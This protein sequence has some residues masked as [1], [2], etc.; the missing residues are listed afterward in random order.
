MPLNKQ[1]ILRLKF[2][3][4]NLKSLDAIKGKLAEVKTSAISTSSGFEKLRG[5]GRGV[6]ESFGFITPE[7]IAV[8]QRYAMQIEEIKSRHAKLRESAVEL[9]HKYALLKRTI[10]E[11]QKQ[12]SAY[13]DIVSDIE[14]HKR[15]LYSVR[16]ELAKI[17]PQYKTYTHLVKNTTE[18]EKRATQEK[19]RQVFTTRYWG[20]VFENW[21]GKIHG[22]QEELSKIEDRR[23][24]QTRALTYASMRLGKAQ[25][26]LVSA[27]MSL[28]GVF[29]S[30]FSA[31]FFLRTGFTSLISPITDLDTAI[32][33]LVL[34][35]IFGDENTKKLAS[36]ILGL[37]KDTD[38]TEKKT[39]KLID[40][41][42]TWQSIT[43]TA[44]VVSLS[45]AVGILGDEE[46]KQKLGEIKTKLIEIAGDEETR[47]AV[48]NLF[49]TMLNMLQE[50]LKNLP[51]IINWFNSMLG[52]LQP[53]LGTVVKLSIFAMIFMIPLAI[54][55]MLVNQ[56]IILIGVL[57][58]LLLWL[59]GADN[60][61]VKFL[62]K[63]KETG[64][65]TIAMNKLKEAI[66]GV[67]LASKLFSPYTL[68]LT[69][70]IILFAILYKKSD[71][72]REVIQKIVNKF[73]EF[74]KTIK[75][76][77]PFL[78]LLGS[79]FGV[80]GGVFKGI[81]GKGVGE[82]FIGG[83]IGEAID[84]KLQ[85]E[86]GKRTITEIGGGGNV[87]QQSSQ[88][89]NETIIMHNDID[90]IH[91]IDELTNT[92]TKSVRYRSSDAV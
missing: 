69:G 84:K 54:I 34:G 52:I 66:K 82:A 73:K 74:G 4:E 68:I 51:S 9:S 17:T 8:N 56:I 46:V 80:A 53:I 18:I 38:D 71:K 26:F 32:N 50:L 7:I 1:A 86:I 47:N 29:F 19:R 21:L 25:Q 62:A 10:R 85:N 5:V 58:K 41:W 6:A 65:L 91:D 75:E 72:F 79:I 36:S 30:L 81:I 20:S 49:L 35:F 59:T 24:R 64:L 63:T 48:K 28:L 33:S 83:N 22:R 16:T 11:E 90:N 45:I 23:E 70:L 76:H 92:L 13:P 37:G 61:L 55:G 77:L 15:Q 43:A 78:N 14:M 57:G 87:N 60:R 27:Q 42:K 2:V 89:I 88:I 3:L 40:A 31:F 12:L 39:N 44:K 67:G